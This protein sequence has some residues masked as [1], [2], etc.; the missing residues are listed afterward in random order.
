MTARSE[1]YAAVMSGGEH[2]PARSNRAS[3]RIDAFRD[4]V[5]AEVLAEAA[6]KLALELTPE[7]PGAGP[8]FLLALRLS[9][10]TLRRMADEAAVAVPA[11]GQDDTSTATVCGAREPEPRTGTQPC[12]LP[13]GHGGNR[14]RDHWGNQWPTAQDETNADDEPPTAAQRAAHEIQDLHDPAVI[15]YSI[16][17]GS[18]RLT[19]RPSTQ[20]QWQSWQNQLAI[21]PGSTTYKGGYADAR[22]QWGDVPVR[23]TCHLDRVPPL[24]LTTYT[25]TRGEPGD[26]TP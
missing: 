16:G 25:D 26:V 14:H 8:G 6:D 2:S 23:V 17:L 1:L 9:M 10:R 5:R 24:D 20:E 15:G 18:L 12:I 7:Q 21:T 13:A 19:L 22:G 11:A 4:E 3:E